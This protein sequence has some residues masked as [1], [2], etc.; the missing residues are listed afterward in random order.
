MVS[1]RIGTIQDTGG[2][3]MIQIEQLD[4]REIISNTGKVRKQ[5]YGLFKCKFCDGEI[6][7]TIE[8][9]RKAKSCSSCRGL[10]RSAEIVKEKGFGNFTLTEELGARETG[11]IERRNN[12]MQKALY[13]VFKCGNCGERVELSYAKTRKYK[14]CS[15]CKGI[16]HGMSKTRPYSIWRGMRDRCDN[17]KNKKFH[18]YGG[19]GIKVCDRWQEF[20]NFWNDMKD[21]YSEEMTID[22]E[23]S[24]KNYSPDNCRWLTHKENS[25]KTTKRRPVEQYE[26]LSGSKEYLTKIATYESI[27]NASKICNIHPMS[28][29]CTLGGKSKTAGG[30]GWRYAETK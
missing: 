8:S 23:N 1:F 25:S 27:L 4:I 28:I 13:G 30:Y 20:E 29:Q 12:T 19:K 24:S 16:K 22:R 7:T 5:R 6:E 11:V 2:I 26:L 14:H 18:I 10:A 15:H 21:G 17:S 3:I 9:G